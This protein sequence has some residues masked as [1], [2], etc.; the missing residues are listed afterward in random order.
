MMGLPPLSVLPSRTGSSEARITFTPFARASS[1]MLA[2][3]PWIT[4]SG[5]GP[6]LPEM[7]FVPARMTTARGRRAITSDRKR[8][9]IWPLV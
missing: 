4:S 9:S 3:F 6:T 8:A 5:T 7:S 1:A 2:R